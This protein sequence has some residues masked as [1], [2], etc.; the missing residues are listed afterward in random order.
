MDEYSFAAGNLGRHVTCTKYLQD[1]F[2]WNDLERTLRAYLIDVL[3][4]LEAAIPP[5]PNC[6][7]AI[8][9]AQYGSDETGWEDR[10]ALQVNKEGTFHC[11]FIDAEDFLK[12]VMQFVFGVVECVN[13][14]GD[15]Q[16]GVGPGQYVGEKQ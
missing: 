14:P 4:N 6:H 15:F 13:A 16:K 5:P 7:H 12:P 1:S 9:Y 2:I 3:K 10:L 11:V 8:T